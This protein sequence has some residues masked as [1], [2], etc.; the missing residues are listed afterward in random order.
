MILTYTPPKILLDNCCF[1]P[2]HLKYIYIYC[3]NMPLYP[4]EKLTNRRLHTSDRCL[5]SVLGEIMKLCSL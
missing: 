5:S 2:G 4:E 1:K 3:Y